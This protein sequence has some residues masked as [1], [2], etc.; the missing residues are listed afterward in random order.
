MYFGNWIWMKWLWLDHCSR[1][2]AWISFSQE[3]LTKTY[4]S[5]YPYRPTWLRPQHNTRI[6]QYEMRDHCRHRIEI[7]QM[8]EDRLTCWAEG[9]DRGVSRCTE[10]QISAETFIPY[11]PLPWHTYRS[12]SHRRLSQKKQHLPS[13][14]RSESKELQRCG[15][16][17]QLWACA[18]ERAHRLTNLSYRSLTTILN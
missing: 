7:H 9:E 4:G 3:I 11:G 15:L 1:D 5:I 18:S 6:Q 13:T 2:F 12:L 10:G 14:Q 17:L 16:G 8:H